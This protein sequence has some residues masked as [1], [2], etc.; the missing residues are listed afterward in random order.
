M[1]V[2]LSECIFSSATFELVI[3]FSARLDIWLIIY[4]CDSS[5]CNDNI[6]RQ[7]AIATD[8]LI[9]RKRNIQ[10]NIITRMEIGSSSNR[11]EYECKF[12]VDLFAPFFAS[13]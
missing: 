13:E 1:N 5:S 2:L 12:I 4:K 9:V 10:R 6:L 3:L 11:T 7:S 8:S